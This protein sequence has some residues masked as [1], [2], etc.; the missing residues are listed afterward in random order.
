[1][2]ARIYRRVVGTSKQFEMMEK[3]ATER[4]PNGMKKFLRQKKR[5]VCYRMSGGRKS[6][7]QKRKSRS[8]DVGII[9]PNTFHSREISFY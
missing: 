6:M 9:K 3:F 1:M 5:S 7:K 8:F 2:E 4:G